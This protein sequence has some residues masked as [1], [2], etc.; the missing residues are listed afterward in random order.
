M[1]KVWFL[2]VPT[3][4]QTEARAIYFAGA[5]FILSLVVSLLIFWPDYVPLFGGK[6]IGLVATISATLAVLIGFYFGNVGQYSYTPDMKWYQKARRV[7]TKAA[8]AFVHGAACFLF[9]SALFYLFHRSFLGLELD[10]IASSLLVAATTSV[11]AYIVYIAA[12][13]ISTTSVS[14]VLA[15]FLASGVMTSM[16][17]A[18]DPY[19][20]QV[21]F[22]SLGGTNSFSSY[23]FNLT[24]IIAGMVTVAL[25]DFVAEDF[26]KL[27]QGG[28]FL[29]D[30]V[31]AVRGSLA[32]IGLFLAGVG[33]FPYN[34]FPIIHLL[35]AAGMA[36]VFICLLSMLPRLMPSFS[37]AFFTMSFIFL[38]AIVAALVLF[39]G[40]DYLTLTAFELISAVIIFSWLVVFIRQIA[41]SL[42][43][44]SKT[45]L[46]K[47]NKR[48]ATA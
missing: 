36:I 24:L 44:E 41:S 48:R 27:K 28:T 18:E 42:E 5:V 25:S 22:S 6:S 34:V 16:I 32:L 10:P 17:T 38:G 4:Q 39:K 12:Y 19:W 47:T 26:A 35:T 13:R 33:A 8:L 9:S 29:I 1:K 21:H 3:P 30:K 11:S 20:W 14:A 46:T 31:S 2:R 23:A 15:L 43:A 37:H 40:F 7:I 45:K